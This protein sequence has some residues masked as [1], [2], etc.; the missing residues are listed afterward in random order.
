MKCINFP[1]FNAYFC[2]ERNKQ[3][4]FCK[5]VSWEKRL[6][7]SRILL[8]LTA[9]CFKKLFQ[10]SKGEETDLVNMCILLIFAFLLR[11]DLQSSLLTGMR[12]CQLFKSCTKEKKAVSRI[13][14]VFL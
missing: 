12:Q 4:I 9:D 6:S 8:A 7:S 2:P 5:C 1:M 11:T 3:I 10:S 14:T 13:C